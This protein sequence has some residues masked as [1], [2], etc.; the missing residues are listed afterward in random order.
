[1]SRTFVAAAWHP[2][3]VRAVA[4]VVAALQRRGWTGV[5][6]VASSSEHLLR[7]ADIDD[8]CLVVCQRPADVRRLVSPVRTSVVLAGVSEGESAEKHAIAEARAAGVTSI[9]VLDTPA[10][11][12]TRVTAGSGEGDPRPNVLCVMNEYARSEIGHDAAVADRVVVV[13]HPGL[14]EFV[15]LRGGGSVRRRR[16]TRR[17]LDIAPGTELITFFSQPIAEL[18]GTALGFTQHDALRIVQQTVGQKAPRRGRLGVA[19][20]PRE[21]VTALRRTVSPETILFEDYDPHDLY[22]ASDVVVSCFSACLAEAVLA[23]R[24]AVSL[25]PGLRGPDRCWTNTLCATEAVYAP[26]RFAPALTRCRRMRRSPRE[27]ARRRGALGIPGNA[28]RRIVDLI[29]TIERQR[30][31]CDGRSRALARRR[32]G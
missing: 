17:R 29:E 32:V 10:E 3:S 9:A 27:L 21:D 1:M 28:V 14:D 16:A 12:K 11:A 6:A 5:M 23:W 13:G 20:H 15:R 26:A 31:T 30:G 19:L 4:P 22:A 7:R 8:R 24:P 25:Q 18:Y 2:G